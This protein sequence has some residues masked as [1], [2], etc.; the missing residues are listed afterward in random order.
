MAGARAGDAGPPGS[1]PAGARGAFPSF[2][3]TACARGWE[4][5]VSAGLGGWEGVEEHYSCRKK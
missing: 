4:G 2:R 1:R 3:G 5:S